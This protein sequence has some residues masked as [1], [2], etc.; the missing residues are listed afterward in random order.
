MKR[1]KWDYFVK[2]LK[3]L[4]PPKNFTFDK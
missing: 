4:E 2:H 1:R 3:G